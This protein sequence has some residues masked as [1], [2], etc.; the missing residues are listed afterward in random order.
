MPASRSTSASRSR[1]AP[2]SSR[3]PDGE[4]TGTSQT[5]RE[6]TLTPEWKPAKGLAVRGEVRHDW[7][8]AP[9]FEK[10]GGTCT[11]QTTA[12][13]NVVYIY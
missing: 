5:L 12:A 8:A 2:S 3:D 13:L 6:V 4:R 9:V 1:C 7:S 11:S 10:R